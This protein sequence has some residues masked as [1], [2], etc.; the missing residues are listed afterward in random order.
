MGVNV[1]SAPAN[2]VRTYI[3]YAVSASSAN[4]TTMKTCRL[5]GFP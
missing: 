1:G 3:N 5:V 2:H 4:S